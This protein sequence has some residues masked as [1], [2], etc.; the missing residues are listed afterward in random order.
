MT[1]KKFELV[2]SYKVLYKY[3]EVRGWR[4]ASAAPS[5]RQVLNNQVIQA[6]TRN[7]RFRTI[8]FLWASIMHTC[9]KRNWK[10]TSLLE[11]ALHIWYI[12]ILYTFFSFLK[13][14]SLY[15]YSSDLYVIGKV[16]AFLDTLF[17][18]SFYVSE[19]CTNM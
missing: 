5:R 19:A 13:Y 10:F 3:K 12:S 14:S 7:P 6:F 9:K 1:H 8:Y 16:G 17:L 11:K 4:D 2:I 15:Q 18:T